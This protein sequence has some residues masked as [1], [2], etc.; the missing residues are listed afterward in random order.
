MSVWFIFAAV[1][2]WTFAV[3]VFAFMTYE[4]HGR[5]EA[6]S[7]AVF[8]PFFVAIS[9]PVMLWRIPFKTVKAIRSDLKNK[10]L[11]REFNA[12][13]EAKKDTPNE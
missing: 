12:W 10:G 3:M 13:V 5:N 2:W 11:L 8:W 6:L 4:R 9:L 7:S 1:I